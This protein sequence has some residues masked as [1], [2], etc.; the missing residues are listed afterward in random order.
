MW[1]YTTDDFRY[2]RDNYE[3]NSREFAKKESC[4]KEHFYRHSSPGHAGFLN[5]VS[6][7]RAY[8]RPTLRSTIEGC[9]ILRKLYKSF[10][11]MQNT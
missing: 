10:I 2:K 1:K 9:L 7:T 6:V 11:L 3:S 5:D 8:S 4:I